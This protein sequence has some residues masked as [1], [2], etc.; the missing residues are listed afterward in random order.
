MHSL[1][2]FFLLLALTFSPQLFSQNIYSDVSTV[3]GFDPTH[4]ITG[5]F[6]VSNFGTG[7][8]FIDVNKDGFQDIVVTDQVG[9]NELYLNQGDGS[10]LLSVT[11]QDIALTN[12]LCKGVSVADY[13]NDG[14][15]DLY[16]SCMGTDHL[17]K[18][19]NGVSFLDV[20]VA[21]GITNPYNSQASAWADIN[22]DG[23]LDVYSINYDR[24][25]IDANNNGGI[26]SDPVP[27]AF[28]LSN[29]DGTFTDIIA[30]FDSVNTLKPNLAVTFFDYDNDGD[31]DLYVITDKNKENV[32]WRN[33]GPATSNCGT[34]WCFTDVSV[35]T[36]TNSQVFGMGI[37]TGDIDND[38]D[39]D[40]FFSSIGEQKLLIS[41]VSQGSETFV[42]VSNSSALS[43]GSVGWATLFF[44]YDNDAWIDAYIATHDDTQALSDTLFRNKADGTFENM[45][46][47][48]GTSNLIKSE[49]AAHGDFDNDGKIDIV[50][51]NVGT[52][53]QLFKNNSVN[54]NNW[55]KIKLNGGNN[56]NANAIGS[57][58]VLTTSDNI[59]QI[60]TVT[61]GSSRGAGNELTLH[62]GL[63]TATIDSLQIIWSSGIVQNI[64][65]VT[66]NQL[67]TYNYV[68]Y[69]A[70]FTNGFE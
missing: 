58:V 5:A 60:R 2:T 22:H 57:K 59:S 56:I 20:S 45:N 67:H 6:G 30:M 54:A 53:Y 70:V 68:D 3:S 21:A 18:N 37:A 64:G 39:Y 25:S 69:D 41:Q 43:L 55:V 19:V 62:F 51:A 26:A 16:L 50:L 46:A 48:S 44:D 61:S 12:G 14:W 42:D 8:A 9:S 32:L 65:T 7:Q 23:W 28:Y 47:V 15:D 49:G 63:G 31:Q 36:A 10:F 66:T 29:G 35:A 1:K 33:D 24:G 4:T 17:F 34:A 13:D 11:H 40:L 52:D 27:D 38:G